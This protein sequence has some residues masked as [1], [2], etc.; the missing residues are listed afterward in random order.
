MS[1]KNSVSTLSF[2]GQKFRPD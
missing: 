2:F 1:V